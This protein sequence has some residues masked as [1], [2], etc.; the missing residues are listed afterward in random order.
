MDKELFRLKVPPSEKVVER[1]A[2]LVSIFQCIGSSI[3]NWD[4]D[5]VLKILGFGFGSK[6]GPKNF[7]RIQPFLNIDFFNPN[8]V[9]E[10]I[11]LSHGD[12]NMI[13]F[14]I[15]IKKIMSILVF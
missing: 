10:L 15:N 11:L 9:G 8:N 4:P 2:T 5:L 7:L 12:A 13:C 14:I 6:P 1:I 3:R